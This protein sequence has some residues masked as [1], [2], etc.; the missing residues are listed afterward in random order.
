MS[1]IRIS[2]IEQQNGVLT[3]QIDNINVSLAN[4][5]RRV[6]LSEIETIAFR[7]SPYK[8][9]SI[10]IYKNTTRLNNEII[11]HRLSCI[12]V[13]ITDLSIPIENY[14]VEL[15]IENT[16]DEMI[17]VTTKY[18]K[19]KNS[20]TTKYLSDKEVKKIFP[21]NPITNEYILITRLRPKINQNTPGEQIQ[22]EAKFVRVQPK[23]DSVYSVVSTCSYG[24]TPDSIQQNEVWKNKARDLKKQNYTIDQIE[25]MKQD[26]YNHDA[27]R[28]VKKDSFQF[29]I[30]SI[31]VFDNITL[32][33]KSIEVM[34]NKLQHIIALC[35]SQELEIKEAETVMKAFDIILHNE[36]YTLGKVVEYI[37]HDMYYKK[38]NSIDFIGFN[39]LHPHDTFSVLRISFTEEHDKTYI[40]SFVKEVCQQG[41]SIYEEIKKQF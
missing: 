2:N 24:L 26:W 19:I 20:Q 30:E 10:T 37:I 17:Y 12:P 38:G 15:N 16:T 40:Y 34:K 33:H 4:S 8:D 36:S 9:S 31:G 29:I 25:Y 14:I 41:I 11:R 35:D 28:I 27:K 5:L 23:E 32:I 3:F 21:S 39:Q 18:F 1:G 6:L 7:A 13:Y 22:L